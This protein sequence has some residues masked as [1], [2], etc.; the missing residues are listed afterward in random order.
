MR[1]LVSYYW[2]SVIFCRITEGRRGIAF[3]PG[4]RLL[5]V[6]TKTFGDKTEHIFLV[7]PPLDEI[8]VDLGR[9]AFA[10]LSHIAL[11][12]AVYPRE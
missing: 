6:E 8:E 4:A 9:W 1:L 11:G 12:D 10:P 2:W 3:G 7:K 5:L